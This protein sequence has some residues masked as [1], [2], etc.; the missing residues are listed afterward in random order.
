MCGAE[1]KSDRERCWADH[2]AHVLCSYK[3]YI[4]QGPFIKVLGAEYAPSKCSSNFAKAHRSVP[5]KF[6]KCPEVL[7]AAVSVGFSSDKT[8]EINNGHSRH[9]VLVLRVTEEGDTGNRDSPGWLPGGGGDKS[10]GFSAWHLAE[11]CPSC[12]PVSLVNVL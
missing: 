9:S 5:F 8:E 2:Q 3:H 6:R 11:Q 12:S 10:S 4:L 7:S 1:R